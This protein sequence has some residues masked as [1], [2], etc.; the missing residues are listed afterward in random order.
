[1][2]VCG[3]MLIWMDR[4]LRLGRSQGMME[5][6]MIACLSDSASIDSQTLLFMKPIVVEELRQLSQ[7]CPLF[8]HHRSKKW[9]KNAIVQAS[10][11][12]EQIYC[13][14]SLNESAVR[15]VRSLCLGGRE[16]ASSGQPPIPPSMNYQNP[17]PR[18]SEITTRYVTQRQ[19][20]FPLFK[21]N[22]HSLLP[23]HHH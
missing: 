4:E 13:I 1:M 7:F 23:S 15:F 21:V 16:F 9:G 6:L 14:P 17:H 22:I 3:W 18:P 2:C 11:S 8:Q 19:G 5:G 10:T 12:K 20:A